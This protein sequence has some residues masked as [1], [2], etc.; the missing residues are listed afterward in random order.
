MQI[1]FFAMI[2]GF[3]KHDFTKKTTLNLPKTGSAGQAR[4]R[5]NAPRDTNLCTK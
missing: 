3:F 5:P 1:H 2:Y 4:Q